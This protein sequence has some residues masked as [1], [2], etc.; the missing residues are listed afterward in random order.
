VNSSRSLCQLG[1][2][3][4]AAA[5]AELRRQLELGKKPPDVLG[6]FVDRDRVARDIAANATGRFDVHGSLGANITLELAADRDRACVDIRRGSPAVHDREITVDG[7]VSLDCALEAE[8]S[9]ARNATA[10]LRGPSDY[11]FAGT[12]SRP[13][14][15]V[16]Y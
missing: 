14:H 1:A 7:D 12:R 11:G 6:A 8:V 2:T 4:T 5:T 15:R 9:L 10:H 13:R 3:L 16:A